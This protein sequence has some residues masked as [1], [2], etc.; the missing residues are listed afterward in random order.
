MILSFSS[1]E[2]F[3]DWNPKFMIPL[4][5]FDSSACNF[6]PKMK[7]SQRGPSSGLNLMDCMI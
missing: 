5:Q 2:V 4:H 7:R 1:Q 3:S 6:P